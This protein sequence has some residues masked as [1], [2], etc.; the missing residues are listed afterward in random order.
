MN[1]FLIILQIYLLTLTFT[2]D[3][4]ERVIGVLIL[5]LESCRH[6]DLSVPLPNFWNPVVVEQC[7]Q[8]ILLGPLEGPTFHPRHPFPRPSVLDNRHICRCWKGEELLLVLLPPEQI[9]LSNA[10]TYSRMHLVLSKIRRWAQHSC[11]SLTRAAG[12]LLKTTVLV[13][14]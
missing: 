2:E 10:Q 11:L 14:T 4:T 7:Q 1:P 3:E 13:C 12:Q 8:K 5:V 6:L 9:P